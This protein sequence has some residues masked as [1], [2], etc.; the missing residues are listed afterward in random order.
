MTSLDVGS[1]RT[2]VPNEPGALYIAGHDCAWVWDSNAEQPVDHCWDALTPVA[3]GHG[4]AHAFRV[5]MVLPIPGAALE[6]DPGTYVVEETIDWW[7]G[8]DV[9]AL[10]TTTDPDGTFTIRLTYVAR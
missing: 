4:E 6:L 2:F 9:D 10:D 8:S 1:T 3:I 7:F 5:R